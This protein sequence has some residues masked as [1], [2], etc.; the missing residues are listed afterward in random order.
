MLQESFL[1]KKRKPGW[2]QWYDSDITTVVQES[3]EMLIEYRRAYIVFSLTFILA[4]AHQEF[5]LYE[6]HSVFMPILPL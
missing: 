3:S 6:R 1:G 2:R 4:V 5:N